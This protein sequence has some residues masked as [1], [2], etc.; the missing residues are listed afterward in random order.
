MTT[1]NNCD[2]EILKTSEEWHRELFPYVAILDPDGW[3]RKN[4]KFS[5]HEERI[6]KKEFIGRLSMSTCADNRFKMDNV[7]V[8]HDDFPERGMG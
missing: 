5:F 3:D 1:Q 8:R 7:I 6:S 4:L 2:N